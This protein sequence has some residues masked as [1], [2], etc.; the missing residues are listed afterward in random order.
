MSLPTLEVNSVSKVI[1]PEIKKDE[2][3]SVQ[4]TPVTVQNYDEP[5]VTRRELWSYYRV[6]HYILPYFLLQYH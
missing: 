4:V 1:L 3:T 6:Y 2:S 5:V